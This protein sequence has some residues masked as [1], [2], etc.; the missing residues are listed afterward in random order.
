MNLM[1]M[2]S[3]K[4][5]VWKKLNSLDVGSTTALWI[6]SEQVYFY[7]K[8]SAG[9]S[10][11][12]KRSL[13]V[14][15]WEKRPLLVI[16]W[17]K[18]P[19]LVIPWEKKRPLLVIPWEKRLLLVIPWEKRPLLV[20]PWEKRLLLV[21]PWEKTIRDWT[22]EK[23]NELNYIEV[24]NKRSGRKSDKKVISYFGHGREE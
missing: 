24:T 23:R 7:K 14:I 11:R 17:E 22:K 12:K 6:P 1:Q 9:H 19:L 3:I 8:A 15:P 13:L 2:W 10:L 18:S 16:P 21:I 20:I 5:M 4:T